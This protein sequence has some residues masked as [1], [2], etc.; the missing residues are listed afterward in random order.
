MQ[1]RRLFTPGPTPVSPAASQ[2]A[3]QQIIHHR[4][5]EF[6]RLMLATRRNLQEI[7][8]TSHDIV[9]LS[10]SGTAA[11]E[12]AVVNMVPT[13]SKAAV[14]VAGKFGERWVELCQ[15]HRRDCVTLQKE[16]GEAANSDEICQ[17]LGSAPEIHTLFLQGCETSTATMHDLESIGKAVRRKYPSVVIV[18][19]GITA[20]GSQPL[21]TDEWGLDIVIGG[22]QKSFALSPGLAFLSLSPL[23]LER[24][25]EKPR[26]YYLDLNREIENQRQGKTAFTPAVSLIQSLHTSTQKIVEQGVDSV[27]EDARIMAAATRAGLESIGCKLLSSSPANAVTAAFA[28]D[29]I[30]TTALIKRLNDRFDLKVAGGQG[31]LKG[32]IFRVAHLGYFDL[33]D[34]FSL[35]GAIEL[36]LADL[37]DQPATGKAISAALKVAQEKSYRTH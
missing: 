11:M 7:F 31:H 12:A 33:L 19:D 32:R 8:K 17:L 37:R 15:A 30:D 22:S 18:V 13:H 1:K 21:L 2:A 3:A 9:I 26:S 34:V 28:P 36:A 14:V 20:V 4:T 24:L 35:L 29:G 10:A 27:I 5:P 23:A 16:Y 6:A 25:T